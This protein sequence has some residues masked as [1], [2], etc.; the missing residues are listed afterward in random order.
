MISFSSSVA[1][2]VVRFIFFCAPS[3]SGRS[4]F[5][6]FWNII[7]PS[8]GRFYKP[9]HAIEVRGI[10]RLRGKRIQAPGINRPAE[11]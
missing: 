2:M 1:S 10:N 11:R 5:F 8:P 3:T 7:M 9:L 4:V 6:V